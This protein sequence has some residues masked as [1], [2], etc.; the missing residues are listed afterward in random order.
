MSAPQPLHK[1]SC[2]LPTRE[3][4][5]PSDWNPSGRHSFG[6]LGYSFVNVGKAL[7]GRD[8]LSQKRSQT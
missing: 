4:G 7:R 6:K 5:V 1:P 3:A 2:H 8:S